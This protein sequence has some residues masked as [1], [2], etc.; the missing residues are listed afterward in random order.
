MPHT[1]HRDQRLSLAHDLMRENDLRHLPVLDGGRLVGLLSRGS[2]KLHR[3]DEN[4][5]RVA[6][7]MATDLYVVAPGDC[8]ADV[9]R[10]LAE[11]ELGCAV[12]VDRGH[13][14][15]IFTAIDALGL[16]ASGVA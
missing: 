5:N 7:A 6:E 16:V 15:G 2:P 3:T 9:A 14:V 11:R 13:V 12:V 10:T 4:M 1:I 8:V